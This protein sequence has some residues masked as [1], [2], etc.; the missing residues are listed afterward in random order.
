MRQHSQNI[1]IPRQER[2]SHLSDGIELTIREFR[3]GKGGIEVGEAPR[4]FEGVMTGVSSY[5]GSA[6]LLGDTL[7][8]GRP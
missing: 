1:T 4:D 5:K 8:S 6:P 7:L 3:L 2:L